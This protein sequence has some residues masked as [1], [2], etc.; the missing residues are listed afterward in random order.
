MNETDLSLRHPDTQAK[1][2][3][4]TPN[5]RLPEGAA[6][7]AAAMFHDIGTALLVIV[8]DGD[9]LLVALQHLIDAKDA[10]VRQALA[11]SAR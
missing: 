5:P 6:A 3:W 8:G 4:L 7:A 2:L 1:M 11:D 10:A 9:Q